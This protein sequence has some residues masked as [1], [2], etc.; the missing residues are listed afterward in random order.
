MF[1]DNQVSQLVEEGQRL[2]R[3]IYARQIPLEQKEM[4]LAKK[5]I[6]NDLLRNAGVHRTSEIGWKHK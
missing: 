5:E 3:Y 4:Y 2:D 1:S 6:Q